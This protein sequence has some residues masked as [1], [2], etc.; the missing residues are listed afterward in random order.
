MLNF[1]KRPKVKEWLFWASLIIFA[2][3][4]WFYFFSPHYSYFIHGMGDAGRVNHITQ[5]V[6]WF[7]P[8]E[9]KGWQKLP[10]LK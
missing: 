2:E 5:S 8:R 10:A 9:E 6:E 7:N 4:F 3:M 1:F